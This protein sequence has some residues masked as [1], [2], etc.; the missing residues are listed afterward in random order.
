MVRG[1]FASVLNLAVCHAD[2]W[3]RGCAGIAPCILKRGEWPAWCSYRSTPR[4]TAIEYESGW[5]P[6]AVETLWRKEDSVPLP[7]TEPQYLW[8][9][10]HRLVTVL[11]ELSWLLKEFRTRS[12]SGMFLSQQRQIS[13]SERHEFSKKCTIIS[14]FCLSECC[15]RVNLENYGFTTQLRIPKLRIEG[16]YTVHG[17]ILVLPLTGRGDAWLEPGE[18]LAPSSFSL[19]CLIVS[20]IH[21]FCMAYL[22]DCI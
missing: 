18:C 2:I 14:N 12:N 15:C 11:T 3:G 19:Q 16:L 22:K 1:K 21:L 13:R 10:A 8:C 7:R 6:Q 17:R 20:F 4:D 9:L 5:A